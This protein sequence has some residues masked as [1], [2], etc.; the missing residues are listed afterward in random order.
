MSECIVTGFH[1]VYGRVVLSL[2]ES[3]VPLGSKLA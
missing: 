1:D 3:D 2:P